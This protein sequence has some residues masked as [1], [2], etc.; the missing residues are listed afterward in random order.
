ML[1]AVDRD[2]LRDLVV[3]QVPAGG[4]L[5]ERD[6][7]RLEAAHDELFTLVGRQLWE[8]DLEVAAHHAPFARPQAHEQ[9]AEPAAGRELPSERPAADN[10]QDPEHDPGGPVARRPEAGERELSRGR[11]VVCG[12]A[13]QTDCRAG[14]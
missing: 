4:H 14:A 11:S 12:R 3:R 1:A 13:L 2:A 9:S 10:G 8:T 6:T 5:E 7:D